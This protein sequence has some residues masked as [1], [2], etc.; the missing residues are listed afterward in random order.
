M[1]T[2]ESI[3]D[4]IVERRYWRRY[5]FT[6]PVRVTI[7]KRRHIGVIHGRGY[8]MSAGGFAL[9]ADA[10]LVIGDEAEIAFMQ[11]SFECR[12]CGRRG[13]QET[14]RMSANAVR[15]PDP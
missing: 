3:D 11:P 4:A 1:L 2:N 8:E 10:E 5:Q 15:S 12:L 9:F 13:W 6:L 7:E 14:A